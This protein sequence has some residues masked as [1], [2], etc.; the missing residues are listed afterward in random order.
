MVLY[1]LGHEGVDCINTYLSKV[2]RESEYRTRNY[3]INP[4]MAA[5]QSI[6]SVPP[7]L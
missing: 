4:P 1:E 2:R 7:C 6:Y 3:G 5:A